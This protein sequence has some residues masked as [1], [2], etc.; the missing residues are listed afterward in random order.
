MRQEVDRTGATLHEKPDK[1][2]L[3]LIWPNLR[4]VIA[5]RHDDAA[6]NTLTSGILDARCFGRAVFC[7]SERRGLHGAQLPRVLT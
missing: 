7:I 6:Q 3:Q 2:I 1:I 4:I 5:L